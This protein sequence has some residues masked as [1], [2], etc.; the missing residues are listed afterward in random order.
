MKV[1][2][3]WCGLLAVGQGRGR[4][5]SWACSQVTKNI[6]YFKLKITSSYYIFLFSIITRHYFFTIFCGEWNIVSLFRAVIAECLK[7]APKDA[8]CKA[9][10]IFFHIITASFFL[11]I[12]NNWSVFNFSSDSLWVWLA[13]AWSISTIRPGRWCSAFFPCWQRLVTTIL[14]FIKKTHSK[15]ICAHTITLFTSIY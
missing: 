11:I 3:G 5:V 2:C 7:G 1:L 14:S 15:Y 8:C 9:S 10:S 12:I 4:Q 13:R 6:C